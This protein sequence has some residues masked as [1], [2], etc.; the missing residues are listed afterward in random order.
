[1]NYLHLSIYHLSNIA[2][3]KV[4]NIKELVPSVSPGFEEK[5]KSLLPNTEMLLPEKNF[6]RSFRRRV[7]H[8]RP[9]LISIQVTN[10]LW[11]VRYCSTEKAPIAEIR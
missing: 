10:S 6:R 5:E 1:M 11:Y 9:K 7:H 8:S 4:T 3:I 2:T